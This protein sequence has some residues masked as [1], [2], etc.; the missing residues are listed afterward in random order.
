[1]R[2]NM[3][4]KKQIER[5]YKKTMREVLVEMYVDKDMSMSQMAEE[6]C[7]AKGTVWNWLMEYGIHK[8]IKL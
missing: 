6:L 3:A 4:L 2:Y 8:K 1:M 5:Y 7:V